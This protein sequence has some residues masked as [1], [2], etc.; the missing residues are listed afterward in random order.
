M[1]RS[2]LLVWL[3]AATAAAQAPSPSV[4]QH[5]VLLQPLDD[6]L[7][8]RESLIVSNPGPG[9]VRDPVNGAVRIFVPAAGAATLGVSVIPPGG[10]AAESKAVK[11]SQ[12][13]V[14][15]VDYPLPPGETRFDFSYSIP[16]KTP[17]EFSGRV[18]HS[19][20]AVNLVVPPGVAAAGDAVEFMGVEPNSKF[21]IYSLKSPNYTIQLQAA[22]SPPAEEDASGGADSLD[23]VLPRVYDR[24]YAI[25]ALGFTALA[26]AFV[27]F[28]RRDLPT[29][30]LPEDQRRR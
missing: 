3:G 24:M 13:Q 4:L 28:Y 27:L 16:F 15:K 26:L 25:L 17:G 6:Q 19:G 8:V 22:S 1:R 29:A 11:T 5:M 2:L 21:S 14:Y 30:N 23:Q 18:L 10:A 9:A 7:V 12:P 20:G